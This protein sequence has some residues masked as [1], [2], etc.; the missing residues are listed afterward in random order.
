LPTQAEGRTPVKVDTSSVGPI[1]YIAAG[2]HESFFVDAAQRRGFGVGENYRG[3]L[4]CGDTSAHSTGFSS[5]RAV[6]YGFVN[7]SKIVSLSHTMIL[8]QN[9]LVYTCGNN[10]QGQ[11]GY[12]GFGPFPNPTVLSAL[13]N[14]IDIALGYAHSVALQGNG[15]IWVW[16][17]NGFG[18]LGTGD[19]L[20]RY[21]PFL[22]VNF[23][24]T[25]ITAIAAGQLVPSTGYTQNVSGHT[26]FLSS[27]GY[28]YGMGS[29]NDGE[30][31]FPASSNVST[32]STP[33]KIPLA[34][35][36]VQI[37]SGNR[38]S[39]FLGSDK[40]V[41]VTGQNYASCLGTTEIE[42]SL[43]CRLFRICH[44]CESITFKHAVLGHFI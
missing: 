16:G 31:G 38:A 37:S 25:S 11:L 21:T 28:V 35:G 3:N 5:S 44:F 22:L 39:M 4:C 26:L 24:D 34:T 30:I 10:D 13:S 32:V 43:V 17:E 15:G 6:I 27:K 41:Y 18:Q 33:T 7:I 9:G 40:K 12:T 2:Y 42:A 19:F 20:P 14:I 8:L 36:I 23:T 29:N 1:A